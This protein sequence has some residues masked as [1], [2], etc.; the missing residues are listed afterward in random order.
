MFWIALVWPTTTLLKFNE[1]GETAVGLIPAPPKATVSGLL[2][3]L[4][5]TVSEVAGTAP[6][7]VGVRVI[8]ML[9]LE[10]PASVLPHVPPVMEYGAATESGEI[11]IG[12]NWRL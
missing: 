10:L 12:V 2:G 1:A 5:V 6:T 7:T 4:V 8:R 11:V 3:A 9:Q